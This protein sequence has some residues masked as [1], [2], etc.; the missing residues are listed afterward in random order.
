MFLHS[1]L[2]PAPNPSS[3]E[4][5]GLVPPMPVSVLVVCMEVPGI[6]VKEFAEAFKASGDNKALS[7]ES[8]DGRL[9]SEGIEFVTCIGRSKIV[10]SSEPFRRKFCLIEIYR[11]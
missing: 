7:K 3:E 2:A 1:T 5:S 4:A 6:L 9:L 8:H 10:Y 11:C